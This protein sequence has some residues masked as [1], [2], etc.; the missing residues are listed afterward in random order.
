MHSHQVK[1]AGEDR[2]SGAWIRDFV[3]ALLV[4]LSSP[5]LQEARHLMHARESELK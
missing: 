5:C 2:G 3:Y 1:T 4:C